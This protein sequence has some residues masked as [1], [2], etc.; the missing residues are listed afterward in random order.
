MVAPHSMPCD[1]MWQKCILLLVVL[2]QMTQTC[3]H[4]VNRLSLHQLMQNPV[5][6]NF[7]DLQVIFDNGMHGAMA[8]A[9][10]N[11]NLFLCDL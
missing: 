10:L 3:S 9:H 6:V 4:S 5:H 7:L 1:D 2:L 8:N 11:M